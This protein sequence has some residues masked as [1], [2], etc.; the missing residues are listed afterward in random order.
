MHTV[1]ERERERK[2]VR[3]RE[4]Q[5]D[6]KKEIYLSKGTN[7]GRWRKIQTERQKELEQK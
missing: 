2:E 4:R 5:K 3:K 6:L 1:G 7:W